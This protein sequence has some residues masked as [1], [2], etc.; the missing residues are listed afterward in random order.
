[1]LSEVG[2]DF[3]D[4]AGDGLLDR[5]EHLFVLLDGDHYLLLDHSLLLLPTSL[6]LL[7]GALLHG[8]RFSADANFAVDLFRDGS[9]RRHAAGLRA[10]AVAARDGWHSAAGGLPA[11]LGLGKGGKAG[12]SKDLEIGWLRLDLLTFFIV[13]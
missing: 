12:G 2:S 6:H 11:D 9:N 8:H 4:L 13:L 7:S 1:M 3:L 10:A 5:A